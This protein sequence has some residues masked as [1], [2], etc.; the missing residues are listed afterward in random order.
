MGPVER[1]AVTVAYA[2]PECQS[3]MQV[4]VPAGTTALEAVQRS[5]MLQRFPEIASR[6]LELAVFGRKVQP[7][8]SLKPGDRVEILRPLLNEPKETRRQL[9]GRGQTMGRKIPP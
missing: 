3:V 2:L 5:G 7:T 6:P 8:M 1:L 4:E 9:A